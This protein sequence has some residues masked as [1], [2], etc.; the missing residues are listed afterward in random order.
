MT[1]F[2]ERVYVSHMTTMYVMSL[3]HVGTHRP[4]HR[5]TDAEKV[6]KS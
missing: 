3:L 6:E 5:Q 4:T 1:A 2:K